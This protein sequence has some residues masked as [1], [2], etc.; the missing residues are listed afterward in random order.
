MTTMR[1]RFYDVA[2][3]ALDE[4]ERVAVVT[5]QI[6]NEAIGEHPRHSRHADGK[7]GVG[8]SGQKCC[9][10]VVEGATESAP[11]FEPP[12]ELHA[13]VADLNRRGTWSQR[14]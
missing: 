2:R 13:C 4:N 9:N 14:C 7:T 5:A 8:W 1:Q 3:E 11:A 6:G 12:G 10:S